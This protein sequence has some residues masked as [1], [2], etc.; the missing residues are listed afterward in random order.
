MKLVLDYFNSMTGARSLGRRIYGRYG[1]LRVDTYHRQI[2]GFIPQYA[3]LAREN[4]DANFR[5]KT[6]PPLPLK[7]SPGVK[8]VRA[9]GGTYP[10]VMLTNERS[11][12][13]NIIYCTDLWHFY[14]DDPSEVDLG[15][16]DGTPSTNG[17]IDAVVFNSK[18]LTSH[19][20]D[21]AL[22][23]GA[24]SGTPD[25]TEISMG[26]AAVDHILHVI[27]DQCLVL[28]SSQG[29]NL[30][31]DRVHI[32]N[33]DFSITK[34][35]FSIG[36]GDYDMIDI[37]DYQARYALL[38]ARKTTSGSAGPNLTHDTTV[39][40][41]DVVA[42]D[43]YDLKISLPGQYQCSITQGGVLYVFSQVG[44][45]LVCSYFTGTGF[46]EV[47]SIN[48]ITAASQLSVPKTRIAVEGNFFVILAY[49][50]NS[51]IT[52]FYWNPSTGES[53]FAKHAIDNQPF[54]SVLTA[55]DLNSNYVRY[56]AYNSVEGNGTL[57]SLEL[58][59][60]AG[61]QFL[62]DIYNDSNQN[63]DFVL[64]GPSDDT[65]RAAQSFTAKGGKLVG[66]SFYLAKDGSPTGTMVAKL[67]AH[68]GTFGSGG[69]P[70][71]SPLATSGTVDISTLTGDFASI[72]FTFTG[73]NQ[74]QLT[75]A[76][77]Y[78]ISFEYAAGNSSNRPKVGNDTTTPTHPGNAAI[79]VASA[80]TA[81]TADL[82]FSV[83]EQ[84]PSNGTYNSNQIASPLI[85]GVQEEGDFGRILIGHIEIEFNAPPPT[86]NDSITLTLTTKDEFESET[87][88]T[89]TATVLDTTAHSTN[90]RV[91]TKR[92]IILLGANATEIAI[93][94]DVV[95]ATSSWNPIIRRIVVVYQP[96]ALQT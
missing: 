36:S 3:D 94:V 87:Y 4:A 50:P 31:R 34:N 40:L 57:Y 56:L 26:G 13:G 85:S 25:W 28:D 69:V 67:Y 7:I 17:G 95:A 27:E 2:V 42:G 80:W 15:I 5:Q 63:G 16:P 9:K 79:F 6:N 53:F 66:A 41:W 35:A 77:N 24:I 75:P 62:S 54:Q 55:L 39:F 33:S 76:A 38:F 47:R 93:D 88:T 44:T 21:G 20:L 61:D 48:G 22:Y 51:F 46:K 90:A 86:E 70:T 83:I 8:V 78:F 74:I 23:Y 19:P 60:D 96:I 71:G 64:P 58:E 89:Q 72:E 37:A 49:A 45:A 68:S 32:V 73:S 92:A 1:V 29:A 59:D 52:P 11:G 30:P 14:L 10:T 81:E 82:I 43:S 18:I 65:S 84:L 91:D 12:A